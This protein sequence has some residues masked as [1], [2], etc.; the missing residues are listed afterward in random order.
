M[1]IP[2]FITAVAILASCAGDRLARTQADIQVLRSDIADLDASVETMTKALARHQRHV[3]TE[4]QQRDPEGFDATKALPRGS[5]KHPDVILLSIDT[6][7]ADHLG[8]WGYERDT[9]PFFDE[10][11]GSGTRFANAWAAAPWTLPSHA[12]ML[13]GLLPPNHGAIEDHLKIGDYPLLQEAFAHQGYGTVGVVSTLFVSQRYG[14]DR[15]FDHFEDFDIQG[16]AMNNA[17]TVDAE[18]VFNHALHWSQQQEDGKPL[19]LFLHV[20][21]VH[22]GYNAPPPYNEQFDRPAQLG[23]P[24]YKEYSFYR[25]NPLTPDQLQLQIDQY[26]EEIAYVDASFRKLVEGWRANGREVVVAIT[27]DHGEE[28]GERGSWGHAHTLHREQLHVPWILNGVGVRKQVVRDRVGSE[29]IAAT[30]AGVAGV[31]FPAAD[32]VNRAT[33]ARTGAR[34]A[35]SQTSGRFAETS[36]FQ[37]LRYRWHRGGQDM[38]VDIANAKRGLCDLKTDTWCR[39]N[40]YTKKGTP[41]KGDEL[42]AEMMDFLGEPWEANEP[43]RVDVKDGFIYMGVERHRKQLEVQAGDRFSV[44]PHDAYV[45]FTSADSTVYGPYRALGGDLPDDQAPVS[46]EGVGSKNASIKLTDEEREMLEE[47]G[48]LQEEG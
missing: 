21:D 34:P 48:Y 23:D 11:A 38:I 45:K 20:Y 46:Y 19:F 42:F 18:H 30:L 22:Y 7:R 1:R 24:I 9:S 4:Q 10:L 33:Q 40:L 39:T 29:D 12:T 14:F 2:L 13:S 8:A 5:K 41:E 15:G 16:A 17:A 36:R 27:A 26:D 37:T 43:G 44:Q 25:K 6:L 28:F 31:P 3:S 47:L 35:Q 32:G